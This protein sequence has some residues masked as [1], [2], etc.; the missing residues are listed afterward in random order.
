ME[1][2]LERLDISRGTLSEIAKSKDELLEQCIEVTLTQRQ[3]QYANIIDHA[4]N[5]VDAILTLLR[6]NLKN[7][8]GHHPNFLAD[9]RNHHQ[10]CWQKMQAFTQQHL[11]AY[12][13]Q[14]FTI[15]IKKQLFRAELNPAMVSDLVI[16]QT[17]AVIETGLLNKST[18]N[19]NEVYKMGFEYYL[20][21]LLTEK[22][23]EILEAR[24]KNL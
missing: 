2:I 19:F 10:L 9:L 7:L 13:T 11:L 8:T 15:G 1:T 6:V 20:R 14:L 3:V 24:L 4:D 16:A 23:L 18:A 5:A 22:G 12:L 17:N 21:G